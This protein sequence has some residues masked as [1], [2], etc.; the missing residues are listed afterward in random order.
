MRLPTNYISLTQK[1]KKEAREQYMKQQ[2]GKCYYCG[3]DLKADT[4]LNLPINKKLFP[5][6]FFRNPHHL[7]HCHKT[8]MTL[9]TVHAKCNA[10]LWQY[11]N[12]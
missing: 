8:G 3:E 12:E 9:G 5:I 11:H 6:G 2:G 1:R 4:T 7:H 10:I